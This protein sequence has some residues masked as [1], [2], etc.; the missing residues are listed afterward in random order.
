MM[1]ILL[2]LLS[3]WILSLFGFDKMFIEVLQPFVEN[4]TLT[5]AH[6]Y[7]V[8]GVMGL[9]GEIFHQD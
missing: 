6:Y 3:G 7:F 5:T 4:V 1:G 9:I 2:G 8:F